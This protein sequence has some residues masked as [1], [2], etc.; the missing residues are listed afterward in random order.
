[1]ITTNIHTYFVFIER[2]AVISYFKRAATPK[3]HY[4]LL[5]FFRVNAA[6]QSVIL[7]L[8]FIAL[9]IPFFLADIPLL[10]P[11]LSWML[12]GEQMSRGFL[13]YRDIWDNVS[14]LSGMVYWGVDSLFG[15][16]Q[17]VYQLAA[18]GLGVFQVL[19]FDNLL[20]SRDIYAERNYIPGL[21]YTLYLTISFD[22]STLSPMLLSSSVLLLA[23]GSMV[24]I[25]HRR[26][27]SSEVF[28]MGVYIGLATLFYLPAAL[29]VFWA[30]ICLLLF[31]GASLRDHLLGLFGTLF[32]LSLVL[33]YFYLVDGVESLN[34]N[35]LTSVFSVRQYELNDFASLILSLF[36]PLLVGLAGFLRIF[37]IRTTTFQA[38]VQQVMAI[39]FIVGVVTIPLM[40]FLAPMQFIFLIPAAVFFSYYYYQSFRSKWVAELLFFGAFGMIVSIFYLGI[41]NWL[42][43]TPYSRLEN[44]RAKPALLPAEINGKKIVVFGEEEGEYL[45]NVTATPYLNWDLSSYDLLNLDQFESVI[46]VY[47]NFTKDP[48]DYVIDKVGLMPKLFARVPALQKQYQKTQWE[49]IYK[50]R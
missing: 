7:I 32:P 30:S 8:F 10:I 23:I 19:Y 43:N 47:D 21:L 14:P 26:Q 2:L 29:F 41:F 16:S 39:W 22:L 11:E 5:S 20:R 1:M 44:L 37:R 18:M 36:V 42:P 6:Y 35:L 50:R 15:R 13:L 31:T 45:T 33:L 25:L 46:H 4:I 34:R 40:Q 49:G 38:N 24:R 17:L 27:V 12:V 3:P 28:E 48:P 9:R